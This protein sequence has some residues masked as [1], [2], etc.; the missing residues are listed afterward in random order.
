MYVSP[1]HPEYERLTSPKAGFEDQGKR[2]A[3]LPRGTAELRVSLATYGSA[4]RPWISLRVWEP[5]YDGQPY[6][7]KSGCSVRIHEI[8]DVI[9][10]LEHAKSILA[11]ERPREDSPEPKGSIATF[12]SHDDETPRY[13]ERRGRPRPRAFDPTPLKSPAGAADSFDEFDACGNR[14][15]GRRDLNAT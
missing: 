5:G 7:T 11:G 14:G 8:D 2:L 4:L 12:R 9:S 6:P 15:D 1:N 13:V 10:A 3:T